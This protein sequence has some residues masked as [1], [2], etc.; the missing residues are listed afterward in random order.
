MLQQEKQQNERIAQLEK[1]IEKKKNSEIFN[2]SEKFA[3]TYKRI[4]DMNDLMN[5]VY[6]ISSE[7]K[8]L[9]EMQNKLQQQQKKLVQLKSENQVLLD[10]NR[11]LQDRLIKLER[12]KQK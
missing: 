8:N 11:Q 1:E 3:E 2:I 5:Q 10:Q 9:K 4:N 12:E 6:N 7:S